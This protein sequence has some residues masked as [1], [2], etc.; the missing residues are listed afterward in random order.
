[1]QGE[2]DLHSVYRSQ[3]RDRY[4]YAKK[5]EELLQIIVKKKKLRIKEE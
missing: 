4:L 1:M 3:C 5:I 2:K